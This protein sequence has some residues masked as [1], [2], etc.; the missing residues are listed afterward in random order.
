MTSNRFF[1]QKKQIKTPRAVL[2]GNEHHHLSRVVRK[3]AGDMVYLFT[4]NG[5]N[6]TARIDEIDSSKTF[7]TIL[8]KEPKNETGIKI[9]LASSLV[10]S[11]SLE[12]ILQKSIELG[13]SCFTPVITERS[14]VNISGKTDKKVKRWNRIA[15][16]ASKQCR[17]TSLPVIE[18]PVPLNRL[19]EKCQ[20][21][22]KIFLDEKGGE[23]LKR[24][25]FHQKNRKQKPPQSVI[26]LIGPEGGWTQKEKQDIVH[27]GF[28]A[29]SL[30]ANVLRTETAA[31]ACVSIISH[32][33]NL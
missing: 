22:L 8:K 3:K 6:F 7:L 31:I 27:H 1:I 10:K 24:L 25:V 33:W 28:K 18:A 20:S 4:E 5:E 23:Y 32:F 30:G 21:E 26:I 17:R 29:V 12:L 13:V 11:K 15:V 19:L 2:T 14:V 16:E 9:T